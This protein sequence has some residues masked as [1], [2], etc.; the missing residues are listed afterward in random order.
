MEPSSQTSTEH[1][2]GDETIAAMQK[3]G[4]GDMV[5]VYIS[6]FES[7]VRPGDVF[8]SKQIKASGIGPDLA[9]TAV[10]QCEGR[11]INKH[12]SEKFKKSRECEQ[13]P[14]DEKQALE[15]IIEELYRER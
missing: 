8:S 6:L 13:L 2:L 14:E 11:E 1:W 9:Y 10:N 4:Y 7:G 15:N 3:C 12:K 5:V